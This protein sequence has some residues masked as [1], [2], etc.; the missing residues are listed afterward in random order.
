MLNT[1]KGAN[2]ELKEGNF[3]RNFCLTLITERTCEGIHAQCQVTQKLSLPSSTTEG[4]ANRLSQ[5]DLTLARTQHFYFA[6]YTS[7]SVS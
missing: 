6:S 5:T 1:G 3:S 4:I 2:N 7:N